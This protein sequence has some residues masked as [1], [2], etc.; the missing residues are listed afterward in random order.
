[1]S[2]NPAQVPVNTS[3]QSPST[4]PFPSSTSSANAVQDPQQS[5][6]VP[7]TVPRSNIPT[8][9]ANL[10]QSSLNA[11][12][13]STSNAGASSLPS[14][15]PAIDTRPAV[16]PREGT[17]S[18]PIVIEEKEEG[19]ISDDDV[20]EVDPVAKPTAQVSSTPVP[21]YHPPSPAAVRATP[22]HNPHPPVPVH[23]QTPQFPPAPFT[24]LASNN[25]RPLTKTQRKKQERRVKAQMNAQRKQNQQ[26]H[27]PQYGHPYAQSPSSS[28]TIPSYPK[29]PSPPA[30]E[31]GKGKEK[32]REDEA[33]VSLELNETVAPAAA[34][35]GQTAVEAVD[36]KRN[37][38]MVACQAEMGGGKCADRTCSDLHLDKGIV[39]TGKYR[40]ASEEGELIACLEDDLVEYIGQTLSN[41]GIF[42]QGPGQI[43]DVLGNIRQD[44]TPDMESD[45]GLS[46][47]LLKVGQTF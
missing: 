10:N 34:K 17:K 31:K 12:T 14:S 35:I 9:A 43:R 21:I 29:L 38:S 5:Y 32:E 33:E 11:L 47:L 18:K 2:A 6:S 26:Y 39:P 1:M 27:Q 44:D 4:V 40:R 42:R 22:S 13:N 23:L 36:D 16:S 45:Q 24:M 25:G 15:T 20:I 3:D 28:S 37:P 46:E 19:E 8:S 30:E 7:E 41:D